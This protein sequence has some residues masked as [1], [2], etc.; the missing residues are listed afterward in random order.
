MLPG[1]VEVARTRRGVF[2]A[3]TGVV[4]ASALERVV[5]GLPT[6]S[7]RGRR[8]LRRGGLLV[9]VR[10]EVRLGLGHNDH[11]LFRKA[12]DGTATNCHECDCS[13]IL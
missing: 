6:D 4:A 8:R 13:D 11:I 3:T 12:I 10:L 1:V 5:M 7:L 9:A 2:S